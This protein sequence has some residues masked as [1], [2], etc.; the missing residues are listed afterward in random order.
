MYAD[1]TRFLHICTDQVDMSANPPSVFPCLEVDPC[2][3]VG[4]SVPSD[5]WLDV[6]TTMA[7]TNP[8]QTVAPYQNRIYTSSIQS[9][10]VPTG[11]TLRVAQVD[12]TL[13][14]SN[15]HVSNKLDEKT[16]LEIPGTCADTTRAKSS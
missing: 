4:N 7:W 5:E 15:A 10:R 9:V 11:V 2:I 13:Y 14:K 12:F 6:G 8:V 16:Q 3:S 1:R